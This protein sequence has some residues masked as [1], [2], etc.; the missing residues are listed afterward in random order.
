MASILRTTGMASSEDPHNPNDPHQSEL[1][2]IDTQKLVEEATA[3]IEEIK[4]DMERT[5][6]GLQQ[7]IDEQVEQLKR[8][9][10]YLDHGVPDAAEA[11]KESQ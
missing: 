9:N 10:S 5:A 3:K 11:D 6:K 1:S 2:E 4:S 7:E 8:K